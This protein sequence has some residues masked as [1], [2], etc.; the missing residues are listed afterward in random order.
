MPM[1][2]SDRSAP[3]RYKEVSSE[4]SAWKVQGVKEDAL[5]QAWTVL[6]VNQPGK[7]V[8]RSNFDL[9]EFQVIRLVDWNTRF[10]ISPSEAL[11]LPTE[12]R[13]RSRWP[14]SCLATKPFM[15]AKSLSSETLC[16]ARL[17]SARRRV[18]QKDRRTEHHHKRGEWQQVGNCGEK[19]GERK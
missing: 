7:A 11:F 15:V 1:D 2:L 9:G 3:P 6:G 18:P 10:E 5:A 12:T 17:C 4:A 19:V 14:D 8:Q 13:D 16:M